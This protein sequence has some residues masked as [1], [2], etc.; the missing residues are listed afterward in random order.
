MPRA[1]PATRSSACRATSRPRPTVSNRSPL[2][3]L[4]PLVG[5]GVRFVRD[6]LVLLGRRRGAH[7]EGTWSPPGGHLEY[8]E[9]VEGCARR[10]TLE[11]TGLHLKATRPGPWTNDVFVAERRHYVTA[12]II[13]QPGAGE[14]R[15]VEPDKCDAWKW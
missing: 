5:V 9:S 6:D 3:P 12:W 13:A 1:R 4:S 11:E 14:P 15:V 7:G 8:G 2:S 10:E